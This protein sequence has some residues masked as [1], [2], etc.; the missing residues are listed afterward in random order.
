[1]YLKNC[2][3][4]AGWEFDIS[5]SRDALVTRRIADEPIMLYRKLDGDIVAMEDRCCHRQAPLSL[6]MKEGNDIRCG[7]HGI[8][9]GPDG[10][11]LEI[12]GQTMI[13]DAAR[14]RTFPVVVRDS[15][16]W[17]W[18]G[19]PAQ[20][21]PDLICFAVGPEHPDWHIKTGQVQIDV[22]Y[23]LEIAN[24]MDL[25]HV[26][27]VHSNTLGG[28]S[29]WYTEEKQH[30]LTERGVTTEFWMPNAAP[31]T[32]FQHVFPPGATFDLH[33]V[34]EMTLPCNFILHFQAWTPGTAA[35]GKASGQLLLDSYSSQA[36]TPRDA[37]TVDYYY[38]WGLHRSTDAPGM[39][40]MFLDAVNVG[41]L[42]DKA[43]LEAQQRNIEE[44]PDGNKIDIKLDAG[45][46]KLLWLLD[47]LIA[48]ENAPAQI[49][50]AG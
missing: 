2:W 20:A 44:R 26:A 42:E 49:S 28:T 46:N 30:T 31:P 11:C 29:C 43:I 48:E 37:R 17:V 27:W 22:S 50:S 33:A 1:M 35:N 25:S 38:S 10:R 34:I 23:R 45:P 21:D 14:V 7:Y 18:M 41:F 3:Y 36:V 15:W 12:P 6:G 39:S 19:D 40:E 16:V 5:Q 47:K 8:K 4:C 24:L 13:P 32:Y 9:F